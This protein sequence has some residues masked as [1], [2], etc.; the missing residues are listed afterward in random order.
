MIDNIRLSIDIHNSQNGM[1]LHSG[2]DANNKSEAINK[3]ITYINKNEKG[4]WK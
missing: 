4:V 1:I 3:F 2:F